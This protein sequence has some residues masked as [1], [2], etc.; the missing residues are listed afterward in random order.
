MVVNTRNTPRRATTPP[1]DADMDYLHEPLVLHAPTDLEWSEHDPTLSIIP[2]N[3]PA[4]DHTVPAVQT[5]QPDPSTL[6]QASNQP[7]DLRALLHAIPSTVHVEN[8]A[9]SV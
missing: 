1:S 6:Q 2:A 3:H 8:L 9:L 5:T 7:P 4:H